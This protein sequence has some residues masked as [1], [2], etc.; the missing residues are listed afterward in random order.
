MIFDN[1][2]NQ[3][4]DDQYETWTLTSSPVSY[5]DFGRSMFEFPPYP[6]YQ[7]SCPVVALANQCFVVNKSILPRMLKLMN[8]LCKRH[9]NEIKP[10]SSVCQRTSIMHHTITILVHKMLLLHQTPVVIYRWLHA[11]SLIR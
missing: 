10:L 1:E 7:Q 2:P 6:G 3:M 11:V 5:V 8:I 4:A 9:L